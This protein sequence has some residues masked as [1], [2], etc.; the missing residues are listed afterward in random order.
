[1][2]RTLGNG[3]FD[4]AFLAYDRMSPHTSELGEFGE[5]TEYANKHYMSPD[6]IF[7]LLV[8]FKTIFIRSQT[9]LHECKAFTRL[10]HFFHARADRPCSPGR[11]S[12]IRSYVE[13]EYRLYRAKL[14]TL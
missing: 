2:G 9:T 8:F 6:T 1:M 5:A 3:T 13:S 12:A 10:G 4:P 14:K 11:S 7:P